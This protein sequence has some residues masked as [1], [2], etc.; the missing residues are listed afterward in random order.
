MAYDITVLE[1]RLEDR[2]MWVERLETDVTAIEQ[3]AREK[4]NYLGPDEVL[5]TF[6]P[7]P[8]KK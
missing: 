6:Y 1:N 7:A 2:K 8:L 3:V 5:V 4:M